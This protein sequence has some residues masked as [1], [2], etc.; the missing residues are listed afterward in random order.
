MS[1]TSLKNYLLLFICTLGIGVVHA[2]HK[3]N[4][5]TNTMLTN[6]C[7]VEEYNETRI[8]AENDLVFFNCAVWSAKVSV[9]LGDNPALSSNWNHEYYC[10]EKADCRPLEIDTCGEETYD[11]TKS[12]NFGERVYYKCVVWVSDRDINPNEIPGEAI[13]WNFYN[14]CNYGDQDDCYPKHCNVFDYNSNVTYQ[15]SNTHVYY[16]CAVWHN[17]F[18]INAGDSAPGEPGSEN[19]WIRDYDCTEDPSCADVPPSYCGVP[20]FNN[21][22]DYAYGAQVYYNCIIWYALV[23]I[24]ANQE[25]PGT[26]DKWAFLTDCDDG[27][28]N[29]PVYNVFCDTYE[30]SSTYPYHNPNTKVVYNCQ[31]YKNLW[32]VSPGVTPGEPGSDV[33]EYIEDCTDPECQTAGINDPYLN[34]NIIFNSKGNHQLYYNFSILDNQQSDLKFYDIRGALILSTTISTNEGELITPTLQPG[35]YL[36]KIYNNT[37]VYVKRVIIY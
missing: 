18:Y 35:V 8:Y 9:A 27:D 25:P 15:N 7:G 21:N 11:F 34:E 5:K 36:V 3:I 31:I 23:Y 22:L 19:K 26:S 24:N 4:N 33:W 17:A 37:N 14:E 12:Y 16:N 20:T 10:Y 28:S 1:V 29:C 30:Y 6:Y 32:W 13:G 2:T